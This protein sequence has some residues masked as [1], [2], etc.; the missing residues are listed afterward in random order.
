MTKIKKHYLF[1]FMKVLFSKYEFYN[2]TWICLESIL[3]HEL[4]PK[5]MGIWL[6]QVDET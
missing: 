1:G 2:S 4:E 6:R 5:K 3:V